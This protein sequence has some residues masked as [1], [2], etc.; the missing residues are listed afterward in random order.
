VGSSGIPIIAKIKCMMA[1]SKELFGELVNKIRLD[2]SREEVESIV[3]LMLES[4]LGLTKTEV[5]AGKQIPQVDYLKWEAYVVRLNH[6]EPVQY[7]LGEAWFYG[8]KF[9]VSPAVLI[10]RPETEE[11]IHHLTREHFLT[12]IGGSIVDIGTGS[13]CIAVTLKKEWPHRR[14]LATD[15]SESALAVARANALRHQADIEF[16]HHNILTEDLPWV[17]V[18]MLV[19][20][21][22][23]ISSA[24]KEGIKPNV[25][26]HE[27]ALAL[28]APEENPL[29]FYDV[30]AKKGK[31]ML[32]PRGRIMLEINEQFGQE[33]ALRF[34]RHGYEQVT[35]YPDYAGKDRII[36]A[37]KP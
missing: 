29:L 21:P 36:S 16:L 17:D 27:P 33:L 18:G 9:G 12:D 34:K 37:I 10:P 19:S 23:Y 4:V 7:I 3:Y 31:R 2:E 35:V 1:N 11:M 14:V 20:N 28:F 30:I 26:E 24:E 32:M 6:H 13:G 15:V 8:R 25:L 5:L 22:P